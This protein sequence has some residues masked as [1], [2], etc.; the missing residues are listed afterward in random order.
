MKNKENE[1]DIQFKEKVEK[2]FKTSFFDVGK[3]VAELTSAMIELQLVL[4]KTDQAPM[5]ERKSTNQLPLEAKGKDLSYP[6]EGFKSLHAPPDQ[7][8]QLRKFVFEILQINEADHEKGKTEINANR[9]KL[10][11]KI[12]AEKKAKAEAKAEKKARSKRKFY[13]MTDEQRPVTKSG[14]MLMSNDIGATFK[15]ESEQL[16]LNKELYGELAKAM[17]AMAGGSDLVKNTAKDNVLTFLEIGS[18]V[19][20][21]ISLLDF[22]G[23][24]S[25]ETGSGVST[26]GK[27]LAKIGAAIVKYAKPIG[28]AAAV[29]AVASL[30]INALEKHAKNAITTELNSRFGNLSLSMEELNDIAH[31][32]LMSGNIKKYA[33]AFQ[34]FEKL[35]NA[36]QFISEARVEL[37]KMQYRLSLGLEFTVDE[38]EQY[39]RTMDDYF[40][41]VENAILSQHEATLNGLKAAYSP[42]E[43]E[44][45]GLVDTLN[46]NTQDALKFVR[47]KRK[48]VSDAFESKDPNAF[49]IAA[50]AKDEVSVYDNIINTK[51]SSRYDEVTTEHFNPADFNLDTYKNYLDVLMA[52]GKEDSKG[53]LDAQK[54][55]LYGYTGQIEFAKKGVENAKSTEEKEAAQKNVEVL[56]KG[57]DKYESDLNE[58]KL[59]YKALEPS[60]LIGQQLMDS[61]T[62]LFPFIQDIINSKSQNEADII[63][64][65]QDPTE[66]AAAQEILK[67]IEG[68]SPGIDAFKESCIEAG[69]K[70]PVE[71]DNLSDSFKKVSTTIYQFNRNN[72]SGGE[73]NKQ[74]HESGGWSFMNIPV[75]K[76]ATGTPHTPNTFIAGEKGA[77]LIT[78]MPGMT[79][80]N[81]METARILKSFRGL[82]SAAMVGQPSALRTSSGKELSSFNLPSAEEKVYKIDSKMNITVNG[83]I[84]GDLEQ[85]LARH[86]NR[87]IARVRE[88]IKSDERNRQRRSLA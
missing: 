23:I 29:I 3:G 76:K 25:T 27:S 39:A 86:E 1:I 2:A 45:L 57:R 73:V 28:I 56:T 58:G 35:E 85:Q 78:N 68:I 47:D 26:L 50:S 20:D 71:A 19:A 62:T 16:E 38:Q 72:E 77:E 11:A 87:L 79:V 74:Y 60:M 53:I 81:A 66:A 31:R 8:E 6:N 9:A 82:D 55:T 37:E 84:P 59:A 30:G 70:V 17:Q 49:T 24:T 4:K 48:T 43:L 65:S 15:R 10:E 51:K 52:A 44:S 32:T 34:S 88:E 40:V 80:Y 54:K 75:K 22:L 33:E 64:M 13:D 7:E 21:V 14:Q 61:Y 67:L 12:E 18:S 42:E 36:K 69:I 83:D 46:E 63:W 41:G 5:E